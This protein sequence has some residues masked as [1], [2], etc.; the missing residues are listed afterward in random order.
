M[1]P[2]ED[3]L[4]GFALLNDEEFAVYRDLVTKLNSADANA[5]GEAA[6]RAT[7][8]TMSSGSGA[9]WGI[10]KSTEDAQQSARKSID[11]LSAASKVW[12]GLI[13]SKP[14]GAIAESAIYE[15]VATAAAAGL[16]SA[17]DKRYSATLGEMS[18]FMQSWTG[19]FV[20]GGL[21]QGG[22]DPNDTFGSMVEKG[23]DS[24]FAMAMDGTPMAAAFGS[25]N[26]IVQSI[27]GKDMSQWA[28]EG[29]L[30]VF[31]ALGMSAEAIKGV[32]EAGGA[33]TMV[34]TMYANWVMTASADQ[35]KECA[36]MATD[37]M[38]DEQRV[39]KLVFGARGA[40]APGVSAT[41]V[42]M[43]TGDGVHALGRVEGALFFESLTGR[44]MRSIAL[45]HMYTRQITPTTY[46]SYGGGSG[47]DED[48][49]A[50]ETEIKNIALAYR[51]SDEFKSL[52]DERG[53]WRTWVHD[54]G[55]WQRWG[56]GRP[57]YASALDGSRS[58]A[59]ALV[60]H[61]RALYRSKLLTFREIVVV[62]HHYTRQRVDAY[63]PPKPG[64]LRWDG[65]PGMGV[66][67]VTDPFEAN[68]ICDD[69]SGKHSVYRSILLANSIVS[70]I[71]R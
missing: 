46:A 41:K 62:C 20:N 59:F 51:S 56:G 64:T 58:D 8:R 24:L 66:T 31:S 39:R 15:S 55:Y 38:R 3:A 2:P 57:S 54:A 23:L 67:F 37:M 25:I 63:D 5:N 61:L 44:A 68:E 11:G 6:M 48:T 14:V 49:D 52:R 35:D 17:L 42:G 47:P 9:I 32:S 27:T 33:L 13:D 43:T 7:S 26:S 34:A 19:A 1:A 22:S 53:R 50:A 69:V 4:G 10:L 28:T 21:W 30:K 45:G 12:E 60:E 65:A 70:L 29:L 71:D 16:A 40:V 18:L 36:Q